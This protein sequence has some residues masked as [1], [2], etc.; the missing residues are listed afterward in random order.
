PEGKSIASTSLGQLYLWDA[1]TGKLRW[2]LGLDN[3][4]FRHALAISRDGKKLAVLSESEYA[5]VALD[6]GALVAR[7]TWRREGPD[8]GV[9]TLTISQDF[10][11]LATGHRDSTVRLYDAA[12][13]Q[14]RNRFTVGE[15]KAE[16]PM[17][18]ELSPD[19]TDV[20]VIA[21]KSA[22]VSVFDAKTGRRRKG[23][24]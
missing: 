14:E 2:R 9:S 20:Y 16:Y 13:G 3:E 12:T 17:A 8:E 4:Y 23:F 11:V 19:A 24:G 7:H 15:P 22:E 21:N 6:T 1:A 10:T 18:I 5:V